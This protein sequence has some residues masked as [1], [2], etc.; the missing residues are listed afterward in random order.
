MNFFLKKCQENTLFLIDEFGTG[1]DPELGGALAETFLEE[2]YHRGSYGVIT[3]H[4]TNLKLLANELPCMSNANMLFDQQTLEPTYKLILGEA[5]S[6][7]TFE[8]AQKNGIPYSLINR[9]KKKIEHGKVRFDK[10]LASLQKERMKLEKTNEILKQEEI[11]AKVESEKVTNTQ[12]KI[13]DK[14]E[15]FQTFYDANQR[16]VYLGEKVNQMADEYFENKNKKVLIGEFI[17]LVEI[18]NSKKNKKTKAEK[19]IDKQVVEDIKK[20]IFPEIKVIREKVKK[21]K[22]AKIKAEIEKPKR[23][24][25]VGDRVRMIDGKAIGTIDKIDKNLAFVN[26][27]IFTSQVKLELL[28]YV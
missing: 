20:E 1:S 19:I 7:Y 13:K 5:G 28:E 24:L 21:E 6:S 26:Y 15:K 3:T 18:E 14:L 17:R 4:Y 25:K 8:V 22:Q 12:E 27:G 11:K 23:L 10:S 2:F 9:A 16:L